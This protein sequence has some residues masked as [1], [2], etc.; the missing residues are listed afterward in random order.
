MNGTFP[1]TKCLFEFK[2][3]KT[4]STYNAQKSFSL[5]IS[6]VN[7]TESA[8][9]CRFGCIYRRDPK[10]KTSS[11]AQ[12]QFFWRLH[13]WLWMVLNNRVLTGVDFSPFSNRNNDFWKRVRPPKVKSAITSTIDFT[14]HKLFCLWL[15]KLQNIFSSGKNWVKHG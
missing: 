9:S 8:V 13:Y 2:S 10:W 4:E 15:H 12:F 11:F 3:K 1:V 6:S 5:G 14:D 7:A